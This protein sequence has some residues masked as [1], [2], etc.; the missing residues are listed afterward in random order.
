MKRASLL[1]VLLFTT[2]L[3][4]SPVFAVEKMKIGKEKI[5]PGIRVEFIAETRDTITPENGN[6]P[7]QE[8]DIHLEALVNWAELFPPKHELRGDYVPYLMVTA[9]ITDEQSGKSE[10]VELVPHL[11]AGDGMHY[12]KNVK[13]PGADTDHYTL[14]FIIDPPKEGVVNFHSDWVKKFGANYFSQP[15]TFTYKNQNFAKV[16]HSHRKE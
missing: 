16:I 15:V 5:E 9:K 3:A 7:A 2:L 14:V 6:L 12:A 13:L 4:S 10:D 1:I 11:S 8:T